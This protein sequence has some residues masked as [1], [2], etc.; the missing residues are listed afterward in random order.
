MV[1]RS[2][3][4]AL[5]A[6]ALLTVTVPAR[7]QSSVG[8]SG[9]ATIDPKQIYGGVY[10]QSPDIGGRFRIRPGID[11][12]TGDGLRLASINIDL[13]ALFPLGKS[14]WSLVQGGGPSIVIATLS[15]VN[16]SPKEV[17]AGGSYL[18]GFAHENGFFTEF[19]IGGGGFVPN[20]KV[21]A[22][23]AIEFK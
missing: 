16:D 4:C 11:G 2:G 23:W 8:F 13:I 1:S 14:H 6:M 20:F 12:A 22:G 5:I 21:G 10:W 17:H 19:R 15:D 3:R 7:A 18:F 9:G